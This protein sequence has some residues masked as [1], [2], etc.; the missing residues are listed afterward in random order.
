MFTWCLSNLIKPLQ[1]WASLSISLHL[2]MLTYVVINAHCFHCI[3]HPLQWR[4]TTHLHSFSW[5]ARLLPPRSVRVKLNDA[6]PRHRPPA[7]PSSSTTST[8][9]IFEQRADQW[10]CLWNCN[11][12][13]I[14]QR[15]IQFSC[16][17]ACAHTLDN[18]TP[19]YKNLMNQPSPLFTPS[20]V[21]WIFIWNHAHLLKIWFD[22]CCKEK[23]HHKSGFWNTIPVYSS[24]SVFV[25]NPLDFN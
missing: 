12:V 15:S 18:G 3:P 22:G 1:I 7:S 2:L 19:P 16:P 5:W 13:N 6:Q 25:L 14:I 24:T 20:L 4:T 23:T 10:H 9:L 11:H 21:W 8:P 17:S